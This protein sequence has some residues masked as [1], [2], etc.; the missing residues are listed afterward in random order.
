[1]REMNLR[2]PP[3]HTPRTQRVMRRCARRSFHGRIFRTIAL[4][5]YE[6]YAFDAGT[7][8]ILYANGRIAT[9]LGYST[10]EMLAMSP[11]HFMHEATE[12]GLRALLTQRN[13]GKRC[14]TLETVHRRK[15]GSVYPVE[16]QFTSYVT[17]QRTIIVADVRN[18]SERRAAEEAL[19]VNQERFRS[20]V[21]HALDIIVVCRPDSSVQYISPSVE[22]VLGC[23]AEQV[24][25]GT[26][27]TLFVPEDQ[28]LVEQMLEQSLTTTSVV[29]PML[30]RA[31]HIDGSER[32]LETS[33]TNLLDDTIMGVLI[34]ARDV[35]EQTLA[36]RALLQQNEYLAALHETTLGLM[37][38]LDLAELLYTIALRA[39]T[40]ADTPNAYMYIVSDDREQLEVRVT[41]G[42]F[43]GTEGMR[44]KRG[45]GAAGH[46]LETGEAI[47][48]EDYD[49]WPGRAPHF[50][51]GRKVSI[52]SVP[53][54]SGPNVIGVLGLGHDN[55]GRTFDQAYI[56]RMTSFAQLA[57]IALDN[58][59]LHAASQ[60]EIAERRRVEVSLEDERQRLQQVIVT[61]PVSMALF[62]RN[63]KYVAY[64]D[65]WLVSNK[66]NGQNLI[67]RSHYEVF[68]DLPKHWKQVYEDVLAGSTY[69][70][71]E[72]IFQRADGSVI[73]VRWAMTPWYHQHGRDRRRGDGD[74]Y[75]Q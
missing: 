11:L 59:M 53:L 3:S 65:K 20:L 72:E 25:E 12:F 32:F 8:R 41:L 30:L 36:E 56:E 50:F 9:Q 35:T 75:Y 21:Q 60:R 66:L 45:M 19:R 62:D 51:Y 4:S 24:Y 34:N 31:R 43:G 63:M 54:K 38:R 29:G 64:S 40:V 16:I 6:G 7:L 52:V 2:T 55:D 73:Y 23:F 48:V 58:A 69:A 71:P 42:I 57:S 49:N 70:H 44:L 26:A 22:R 5:T 33:M 14:F 1:M 15:D 10:A 61:A 68:P 39:G 27:M 37:N 18:I 74:G 17:L 13:Q 46:V 47:V 28:P 67:G